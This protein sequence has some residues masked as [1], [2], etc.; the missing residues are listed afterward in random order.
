VFRALKPDLHQQ[1]STGDKQMSKK[2]KPET[3]D[4]LLMRY[5]EIEAD[6]VRQ[7]KTFDLER[8]LCMAMARRNYQ[9]SEKQFRRRVIAGQVIHYL[10]QLVLLFCVFVNWDELKVVMVLLLV[11]L[12]RSINYNADQIKHLQAKTIEWLTMVN[13]TA[14]D[15]FF[16]SEHCYGSEIRHRV[17]DL[18]HPRTS[19]PT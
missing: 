11:M 16:G 9:I 4:H 10:I 5:K 17:F 2:N 6:Q 15:D 7:G 1:N 18:L 12:W 14:K 8:G 3:D 13:P 19:R